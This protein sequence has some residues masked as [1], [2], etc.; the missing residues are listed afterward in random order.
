LPRRLK[1]AVLPL[2][3]FL[4]QPRSVWRC[5]RLTQAAAFSM[6]RLQLEAHSRWR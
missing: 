5:H 3:I 4:R 2:W 6:R 1:Q